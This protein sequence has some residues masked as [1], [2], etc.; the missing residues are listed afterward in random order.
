MTMSIQHG[1]CL[2]GNSN[3]IVVTI[4]IEISTVSRYKQFSD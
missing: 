4:P 3:G 2:C 1:M